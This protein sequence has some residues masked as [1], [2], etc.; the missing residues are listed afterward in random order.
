MSIIVI[1]ENSHLFAKQIFTTTLD[2]FT[3]PKGQ[4]CIVLATADLEKESVFLESMFYTS[5]IQAGLT[6]M[7]ANIG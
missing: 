4:H 3:H 2:Q 7:I 1:F 6:R 5:L